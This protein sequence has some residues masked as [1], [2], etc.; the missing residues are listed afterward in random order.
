M[1]WTFCL[2]FCCYFVAQNN[3]SLKNTNISGF[4]NKQVLVLVVLSLSLHIIL[5][6]LLYK[7][8]VKN[9]VSVVANTIKGMSQVFSCN[10]C[11]LYFTRVTIYC[12]VSLY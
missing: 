7:I 9:W 2:L 4:R 11:H 12:Y 8:F 3:S 6:L 10:V 1:Y 5:F